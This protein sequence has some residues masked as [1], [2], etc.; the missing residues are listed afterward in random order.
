MS[1]ALLIISC[2]A[3]KRSHPALARDM[4][5]GPWHKT[6]RKNR[7]E[8]LCVYIL[9]AKYGLINEDKS[10]D[11]YEL[12]MT[13]ARACELNETVKADYF[14]LI[15]TINPPRIMWCLGKDYLNAMKGCWF[16]SETVVPFCPKKSGIG[17]RM[18]E[19]KEWLIETA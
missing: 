12:R 16:A 2:G 9:S 19:L 8:N 10:I 17:S 6:L 3:K 4:Y 13:P 14:K 11:P 18:T 1:K 7:G 5:L 15:Q